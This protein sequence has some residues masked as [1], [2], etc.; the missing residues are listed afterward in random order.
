MPGCGHDDFDSV[1]PILFSLA[2]AELI[3]SHVS[4]YG[5]TVLQTYIYFKNSGTDSA[6]LKSFV[7][8]PP[9]FL[10]PKLTAVF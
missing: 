10:R 5:I 7:R 4:V 3:V 9:Y 6:R 8:T 1:R 2:C